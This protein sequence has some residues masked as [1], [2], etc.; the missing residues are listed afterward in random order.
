MSAEWSVVHG[1]DGIHPE[2]LKELRN[3]TDEPFS[4]TYQ[5]F[6]ESGE[7]PADWKLADV[8]LIYKK[9][10]REDPGKYRPV[11]LT[12]VPGKGR[13]KIALSA[14]ERQVKDKAIVR[15]S[16]HRFIKGKCCLD[17]LF[18]C[19]SITHSMD[20][21]KAVDITLLDLSKS[22]DSVPHS[23]LLD[24]LSSCELSRF[25]PCWA[26]NRLNGRAQRLS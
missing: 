1:P 16:Q 19:D 20:E 5:R 22:F 21:G 6:W 24:K 14:T 10:T 8:T 23:I 18:S 17:D 25:M 15:R 26:M 2:V 11:S 4:T 13:E 9:G 7:V 3:V 12:S